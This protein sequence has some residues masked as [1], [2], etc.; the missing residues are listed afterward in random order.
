MHNLARALP[1][2]AGQ[3]VSARRGC[4]KFRVAG[5]AGQTDL[6][7]DALERLHNL[8]ITVASLLMITLA[9]HRRHSSPQRLHHEIWLIQMNFVTVAGRSDMHAIGAQKVETSRGA[10]T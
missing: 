5:A 6:S 2:C 1:V 9:P 3:L 10:I 4:R 8:H 7:F